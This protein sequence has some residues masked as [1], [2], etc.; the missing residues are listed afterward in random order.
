MDYFVGWGAYGGGTEEGG[1]ND[2]DE[3]GDEF[4]LVRQLGD[5][6]VAQN[7]RKGGGNVGKSGESDILG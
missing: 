1:E 3:G 5:E 7:W 4:D 2:S 6:L